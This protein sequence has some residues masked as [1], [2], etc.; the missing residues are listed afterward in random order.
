MSFPNAH[1]LLTIHWGYASAT[2]EK[3]QTGIRFDTVTPASQAL[4]D[5]TATAITNFW[6]TN[7]TG[8]IDPAFKLEFARLASI[9]PNGQYVPGTRAYDHT[10]P[11]TGGGAGGSTPLYSFPLQVAMVTTMLTAQPRGQAY[12]GRLYLPYAA[13]AT[14]NSYLWRW[15]PAVANNRSNAVAAMI[16]ALNTALGAK[17]TVFSTGTKAAPA[18]GAKQLITGCLTDTKPDT[19]RRRAKQLTSTLGTTFNI[20]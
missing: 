16:T 12:K 8:M 9:A 5:A 19:Q 2:A 11:G 3:A 14:L 7:L 13:G 10:F 1:L 6:T 15:D 17:A 18:V 20:T 4:V